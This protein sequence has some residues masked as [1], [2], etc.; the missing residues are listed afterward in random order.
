MTGDRSGNSQFW[1]QTPYGPLTFSSKGHEELVN[2]DV[3]EF[4]LFR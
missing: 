1:A 4:E 3:F 2:F